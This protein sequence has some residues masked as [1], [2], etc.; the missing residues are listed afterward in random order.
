LATPF[1]LSRTLKAAFFVPRVVPAGG[2]NV[3][4][5]VQFPPAARLVPQL[6]VCE[7]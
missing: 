3:T 7:N 2:W 4:V 1:E 5:T 6:L